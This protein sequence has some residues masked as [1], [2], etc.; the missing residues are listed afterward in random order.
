M[1][2]DNEIIRSIADVANRK[3]PRK[4]AIADSQKVKNIS[5][6]TLEVTADEMGLRFDRIEGIGEDGEACEFLIVAAEADVQNRWYLEL[7]SVAFFGTNGQQRLVMQIDMGEALGYDATEILDFIKS[8]V[9]ATCPCT[10]CGGK[11]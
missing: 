8:D 7:T 4:L 2:Y 9:S 3:T 5:L 1:S 6:S 11:P 10:C